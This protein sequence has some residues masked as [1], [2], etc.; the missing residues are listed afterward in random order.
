MEQLPLKSVQSNFNICLIKCRVRIEM[1][2]VTVG[3][4]VGTREQAAAPHS[5]RRKL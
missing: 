3:I 4:S 5:N 2:Q 1:H